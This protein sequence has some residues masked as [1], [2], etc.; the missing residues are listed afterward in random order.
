MTDLWSK[1]PGW[2]VQNKTGWLIHKRELYNPLLPA[3]I[4]ITIAGESHQQ[5]T[6]ISWIGGIFLVF[7]PWLAW[8]LVV[9]CPWCSPPGFSPP[10][11]SSALPRGMTLDLHPGKARH[12]ETC[13][14]CFSVNLLDYPSLSFS[15]LS[16]PKKLLLS[17]SL[18]NDLGA[19][20]PYSSAKDNIL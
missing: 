5:P 11:R 18:K 12:Q 10:P 9:C 8:D 17:M 19:F 1:S 2:A 16:S 20:L 3:R 15:R 7:L 4:G 14:P 13:D 6:S